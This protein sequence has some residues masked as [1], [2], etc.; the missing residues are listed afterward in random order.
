MSLDLARAALRD[1][2]TGLASHALLVDRLDHALVRAARKNA[3]V[4]M[5][6][7][8]LDD[9]RAVNDGLGPEAGDALLVAAAD[10]LQN[11]LRAADTIARVGG[12]RFGV[13]LEDADEPGSRRWPSRSAS[14]T[15]WS[16]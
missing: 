14:P 15:G 11:L 5:L 6:L 7:V 1:P 4:A 16:P 10:R 8:D 2:L 9:F 12:D 13:L 3:A